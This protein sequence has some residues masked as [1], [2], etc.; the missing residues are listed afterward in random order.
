MKRSNEVNTRKTIIVHIVLI[1]LVFV[2]MVV[3]L[4]RRDFYSVFLCLLTLILFNIPIFVDRTLKIKLPSVLEIIILLFIFAAEIMGEIGS[5]YTR[6]P[7]WDSMLHTT[8]GF[9]MAAIGFSLIDILNNDPRFHINL[10]PF[11]V[12]F[13]A[14]CFSMTV[15]VVWEFFEFTMD[16]LT[17][18]DMQKDFIVTSVSSVALNPSGLNS[19]VKLPD[20]TSTIINYTDNGEAA[21]QIIYGGYLDVGLIDTMKDMIVNCVGALVFSIIGYLYIIGRNKSGFVKLFIPRMKT[22]EEITLED[23]K[24]E[25]L[26]AER[27]RRKKERK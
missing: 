6:F 10:S 3:R 20:I 21:Q 16:S 23:E 8:N 9:L 2:V 7:I 13:V 25:Q 15:G 5:F 12:A 4:I 11:F 1:L 27:Q 18:T 22:K 26:K 17:G 14:F 19:A 24:I